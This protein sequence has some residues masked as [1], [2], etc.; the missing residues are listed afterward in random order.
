[1]SLGCQ[2]TTRKKIATVLTV[3]FLISQTSWAAPVATFEASHTALSVHSLVPFESAR[4][5]EIYRGDSARETVFFIQDAHGNDRAQFKIVD[6]IQTL[7]KQFSV[8][9]LYV[10]GLEG[11]ADVSLFRGF[12]NRDVKTEIFSRLLREGRVGAGEYAAITNETGLQLIG[13]D[14]EKTYLQNVKAYVETEAERQ[15]G[16]KLLQEL[17]EKIQKEI[18][19]D[20][21]F[22]DELK[23]YIDARRNLLNRKIALD[24]Y[25]ETLSRI[26]GG[27]AVE[28]Q[29]PV[30]HRILQLNAEIKTNQTEVIQRERADLVQ[31]ILASKTL[32]AFRK[33][34]LAELE[35]SYTKRIIDQETYLS[36]LIEIAEALALP[37]SSHQ[38]IRYYLNQA[39]EVKELPIAEL[40]KEIKQ[41]ET[42][43]IQ[44]LAP[45]KELLERVTAAR[46]IDLMTVLMDYAL[47][48]AEY[49][50]LK[51]LLAS[52]KQ[53]SADD[54]FVSLFR[55]MSLFLRF[56]ELAE[57]RN[58]ILAGNVLKFMRRQKE[59]S[60]ILVAGGFHT[61]GLADELRR[62]KVSY[63][64]LSPRLETVMV[65]N[66]YSEKMKSYAKDF[67]IAEGKQ[68]GAVA[69]FSE[70]QKFQ[71][72]VNHARVNNL[73]D[74][75]LKEFALRIDP[76]DVVKWNRYAGNHVLVADSKNILH[77]LTLDQLT[78]ALKKS[79]PTPEALAQAIRNGK[80]GASFQT[81]PVELGYSMVT[82]RVSNS[83]EMHRVIEE[84][85]RRGQRTFI[86][87]GSQEER[88]YGKSGVKER[89]WELAS[90][91]KSHTDAKIIYKIRSFGGVN[92]EDELKDQL[93]YFDELKDQS[94]MDESSVER[95][96][97]AV[98]TV[99]DGSRKKQA[100][101]YTVSLHVTQT[102]KRLFNETASRRISIYQAPSSLSPQAW[103][104]VLQD[105][106]IDGIVLPPANYDVEQI[107]RHLRAAEA[108]SD[109]TQ[110]NTGS[111]GYV[112]KIGLIYDGADLFQDPVDRWEIMA[113]LQEVDPAKVSVTVFPNRADIDTL[114]TILNRGKSSAG[115]SRS[116]EMLGLNPIQAQDIEDTLAGLIVHTASH[117]P[118]DF[119]RA[120]EFGIAREK[121]E[122]GRQ[123]L[124]TL[125]RNYVQ[126][127]MNERP[128]CQDTGQACIFVE[129]G[130]HVRLEGL[131]EGETID[132][133]I[134]RAVARAYQPPAMR[135]STVRDALF[136]RRNPGNNLPAMIH[137][138]I[139]S[140]DKIKITVAE[141]GYGSENKSA[142]TMYPNPVEDITPVLDFV[143]AQIR[144][145]GADWCPPGILSIAVGGNFEMAPKLAKAGIL[146]PFD[147]DILL[148]RAKEAGI[149]ELSDRNQI[150]EKAASLKLPAIDDKD[151]I[152]KEALWNHLV[153]LRPRHYPPL[154]KSRAKFFDDFDVRSL[155]TVYTGSPATQYVDTRKLAQLQKEVE[156]ARAGTLSIDAERLVL[157]E[158]FQ[159]YSWNYPRDQGNSLIW[160]DEV[161]RW[162][163]IRGGLEKY[164][165]SHYRDWQWLLDEA[166]AG[167]LSL[168]LEKAVMAKLYRAYMIDEINK[169]KAAERKG[170]KP[171][172]SSNELARI[173]IFMEVNN[174]G[175]GPQGL[176]G[177]TT[178]VDVKLTTESTH[179]AGMP[180][181]LCV[182]CNKSHHAEIVLDGS[183]PVLHYEEAVLDA[184]AGRQRLRTEGVVQKDFVRVDLP[185]PSQPEELTAFKARVKQLKAGDFVLLN[186]RILTGRDAAHKRM[187]DTLS[188][189]EKLPVPLDGRFIYYVG[190]VEPVA[191]E[192]VG[193]AGPTTASRMN[194]YAPKLIKEQGLLGII[195]KAEMSEEVKR[196]LSEAGGVMFIAIG[197][198]AYVQSRAIVGRK[199]LAYEELGP[200]AIQEFEVKDF[201]VIVAVDSEGTSV[202]A[203]GR[204][205]WAG[206]MTQS[207]AGIPLPIVGQGGSGN[208]PTSAKQSDVR[209]ELRIAASDIHVLQNSIAFKEPD[210]LARTIARIAPAVSAENSAAREFLREAVEG[211]AKQ[212]VVDAALQDSVARVDDIIRS[213]AAQLVGDQIALVIP[214]ERALA[215]FNE[216]IQFNVFGEDVR[217]KLAVIAV[218]FETENSAAL[219]Q[220]LS[221]WSRMDGSKVLI[222][223]DPAKLRKM[224]S[225]FRILAIGNELPLRYQQ[226]LGGLIAGDVHGALMHALETVLALRELGRSA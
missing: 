93:Q 82:E 114:S 107:R 161:D 120:I 24:H 53:E 59:S 150:L 182:Q 200:E 226:A 191:G 77:V 101:I 136:D 143:L 14:Q 166:S 162:K 67:G 68:G 22:S 70:I 32:T 40:L 46:R 95:F 5:H 86:V 49:V 123:V 187:I 205:E 190:P 15:L 111:A 55:K 170:E 178:V 173:L 119:L 174:L 144:K 100:G 197:G 51:S 31:A 195:G 103:A 96:A 78:D 112:K 206:A 169:A 196:T 34:H 57:K 202:H 121:S 208:A 156:E 74:E 91:A 210:A 102:L 88:R 180:I 4:I 141:K 42:R 146:K 64:I 87:G 12:P 3:L 30:M 216:A 26:S 20:P 73:T 131:K 45:S 207:T 21:A 94:L 122:L 61:R 221:K 135:V 117:M 54:H 160:N 23:E 58:K 37:A 165:L 219:K 17:R 134:N 133:V 145:A 164:N 201:P 50:E 175:I 109:A 62:K 44:M 155:A 203:A 188:K 132:D 47:T 108:A 66:P 116:M 140:G 75:I 198:A 124:E 193:P 159:D 127:G 139:V 153:E 183:G 209:A 214:N 104:G 92:L 137:H 192:V 129:I 177:T 79:Y 39:R 71:S 27:A 98:E 113:A 106:F 194:I 199:V 220:N 158:Y 43:L 105:P 126:A 148:T 181:A 11:R 9:S 81:A 8:Q 176:G 63:V 16:K 65:D 154:P 189:G 224:L 168:N 28:K 142:M 223:E 138:K 152:L 90:F 157:G 35:V 7:S 115:A 218:L 128:T 147:M 179:I 118:D 151:M 13:A 60:A 29:F 1:M 33:N 69:L 222:S 212:A 10:E 72:P 171:A 38:G 184:Y 85:Y 172:L 48:P 163:Y 25:L 56:Y 89:L 19:E 186:G 6:L 215:L 76:A 83:E 213:G 84:A 149:L 211:P 36:G 130:D 97:I 125:L 225:A 99:P 52:G 2:P 217:G 185:D 80:I 204:Q 18:K 41:F 167:R 110:K